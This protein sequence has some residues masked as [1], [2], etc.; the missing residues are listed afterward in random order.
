M[1]LIHVKLS[2]FKSFADPT[3]I[4]FKKRITAIVGPNGCGKSNVIDAIRCVLSGAARHLRGD[5]LPDVIFNGS[6]SR[7]PVGQASV[8]ML[9]DNNDGSLGGEYGAYPEIC[10]RRE[11]NRDGTSDY[12]LNGTRCRRKDVVDIFLGTGLG[13]QSYA[14]IEQGMITR[15]IE[16][17]P[18][19]LRVYL[20]EAAGISKY[21]ERRRETE[22]RLES[23]REN[24]ER[25]NDHRLELEKQLAHLQRQANAA[26]K[27]KE[28]KQEERVIKSEL[29]AIHWREFAQQQEA[30]QAASQS[31]Q[32]NFESKVAELRQTETNIEKLRQQ[33]IEVT[34]NFNGIQTKFYAMGA[35]IARLEQ[36]V[37]NLQ[38]RR[39]QLQSDIEQ[40]ETNYQETK[41]NYEDDQLQIEELSAEVEKLE[42]QIAEAKETA[43]TSQA[44][45]KSA[46]EA[47]QD[48]QTRWDGFNQQNAK[49]SQ[50]IEV[51]RTQ[52]QHAQQ[53]QSNA[54]QHIQRLESEHSQFNFA[55]LEN[56]IQNLKQEQAQVAAECLELQNLLESLQ[57]QWNQQR[58]NEKQSMLQLDQARHQL[59]H[60]MG[61]R[62][63]LEA[64]Q[65][66]AL[67][68]N[69]QALNNWLQEQNLQQKSRLAENLAVE[70]GW[71]L[72]VETVLGPYLEAINVADFNSLEISLGQ[73]DKGH[74]TLFKANATAASSHANK[75]TLASK[76]NSSWELGDLLS[77]IYIAENLTA[78]LQLSQTLSPHESVITQQG[79]WLG[80]NWL[81][82][83]KNTD[84]KAGV[85][86]RERELH[87]LQDAI[88]QH[89]NE[90][91]RQEQVHSQIKIILAQL[92]TEREHVQKQFLEVSGK[93][94]QLQGQLHAKQNRIEQ[95]KQRDAAIQQQLAENQRRL[96]EAKAKF[97]AAQGALE[98]A[99]V[100]LNLANEEKETLMQ[101]RET[102][103]EQLN[104]HRD[105]AQQDKHAADELQV[106]LESSRSQ[107]HYLRQT[108]QRAEKQLKDLAE[109]KES[110]LQGIAETENPLRE[111]SAELNTSLEK[112]LA[113]ERELEAA[114][115]QVNHVDHDLRECEAQQH[116]INE[117]IEG[118]RSALEELRM[119][120]QALQIK[121]AHCQEKITE[122]GAELEATLAQLPEVYSLQEW[123]EKV[124]KL[125]NRIQRLGAINLAAIDEYQTLSERK[126]YL[127]AQNNDL[128]EAIT[129][130]EDAIRKIDRE[131][132]ARL[133][134]TFE[135]VNAE[136]NRLFQ[137]VFTGGQAQLEL[138]GDDVLATGMIVKA[139]PPGKRNTTI[140]L[141]SGGEKALTA[142]ALVFAMFHLNPSPFCILDEV[143]APL[144]DVNIGRFCTLVKEMSEKVQ[145]IFISHN[146]L[147]MEIADQ[148]MGITMNEPGVS[149]VVSVD[150]NQAIEMATA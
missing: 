59:Q 88:A 29:Q 38:E 91:Q 72:A 149:R 146:K 125:E 49:I 53:W 5:T 10:V 103:R 134:D 95:L 31:T 143:D 66:A 50:S 121:Q 81:R 111:L 123:E 105:Q 22:N 106:R 89:Q 112:R 20:E 120:L 51:E 33:K 17:K 28:L 26:E 102:C 115:Q 58:D 141:L 74:L 46:E 107:L 65:Q 12:Y 118:L 114:R 126:T 27:Y 77:G 127:D 101:E 61:R 80:K 2:G 82:I 86:Q 70:S 97:T 110:L 13:P 47:M 113:V 45:W 148:L 136:F 76:I 68:K 57:Q 73:F 3:T 92:E 100:K 71:E 140:H 150:M 133:Q 60:L 128:V 98:E 138:I 78:A 4:P 93:S 137:R 54:E 9:F 40:L 63:S 147:T 24:L 6:A 135:K 129:T 132:R 109:R 142:T 8:E 30:E 145:F 90:I 44:A 67:G 21:K 104:T 96:E 41:Q 48:W 7:K 75:P 117:D 122:L 56:E 35:E 11:V 43:D 52:L 84:A 119:K 18:E 23:T 19:E 108:I 25:L 79:I 139:Q 69:D 144:D 55:E 37:Q 16:A 87:E 1:Q 130:L 42:P 83:S 36:N 39:T 131:T 14:I 62:S 64:L 85:I 99:Q 34:D 94:S 116:Q 15:L 32:N 124:T